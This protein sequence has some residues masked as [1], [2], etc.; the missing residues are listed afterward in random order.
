MLAAVPLAEAQTAVEPELA[1]ASGAVT[2]SDASERAVTE[3]EAAAV[4]STAMLSPEERARLTLE[5]LDQLAAAAGEPEIVERSDFLSLFRRWYY[6]PEKQRAG[7]VLLAN[8]DG[9]WPVRRLLN[10]AARVALGPPAAMLTV[11]RA[12]AK[13][14]KTRLIHVGREGVE[15]SVPVLPRRSR[16]NAGATSGNSGNSLET[17]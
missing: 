8:Q 9:A 15:R 1:Q 7:E 12:A 14:A 6:R 2:A 16:R 3:S 17:S 5:R 11:D 10:A 4:A 13:S